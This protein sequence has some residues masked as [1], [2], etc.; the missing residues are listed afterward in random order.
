[1]RDYFVSTELHLVMQSLTSRLTHIT[2]QFS[3]DMIG[4]K[5]LTMTS[6][7][8]LPTMYHTCRRNSGAWA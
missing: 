3:S 4:T 7:P 1:M 2:D 6:R 8:H 5:Y